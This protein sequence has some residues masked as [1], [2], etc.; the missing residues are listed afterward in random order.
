MKDEVWDGARGC[1]SVQ[2]LLRVWCSP[3]LMAA[4]EGVKDG[5]KVAYLTKTSNRRFCR[6]FIALVK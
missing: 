5:D 4:C 3:K 6:G 1:P 2:P